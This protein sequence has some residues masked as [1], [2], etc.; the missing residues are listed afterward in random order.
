MDERPISYGVALGWTF[1][2]TVLLTIGVELVGRVR[3][4]ARNDFVTLGSLEA[5]VLLLATS[6]VLRV[7]SPK[8]TF[9]TALGIRPTHPALLGFS[10]AIGVVL[11]FPAESI[12]QL[13]LRLFPLGER[14][15][16][17][18]VL[19]HRAESSSAA[20]A[21]ALVG[22]CLVPLAE[23]VLFRGALFGLL[24]RNRS[25]AG[26][27]VGSTIA[28]VIA[29][30]DP[31][32]W[33]SLCLVG[34][35]LAYVRAVSGSLFAALALHVGFGAVGVHAALTGLATSSGGVPLSLPLVL[36]SWI[37]LVVLVMGVQWFGRSSE[38][39]ERARAEDEA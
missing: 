27:V 16:I 38:E 12:S 10:L 19:Y 30:L 36:G 33:P 11:P 1:A 22:V 34:L 2:T 37:L 29:H 18:R 3:P 7:H 28:F 5:L 26:A 31:R 25:L 14:A 15:M 13:V 9:R 4:A 24:R 8:R 21:M 32:D 23:E 6:A 20:V 17:E 35:V 39:A